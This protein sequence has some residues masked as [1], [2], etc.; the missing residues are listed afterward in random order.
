MDL[1]DQ[2]VSIWTRLD[3]CFKTNLYIG[4][5]NLPMELFIIGRFF[6]PFPPISCEFSFFFSRLRYRIVVVLQNQ[7]FEILL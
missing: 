3:L 7:G 2:D 4:K 1:G 6:L 5:W